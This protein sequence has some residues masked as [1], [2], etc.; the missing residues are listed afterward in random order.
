MKKPNQK[1]S[2]VYHFSTA[3]LPALPL[4]ERM[5]EMFPKLEFNYRYYERGCCFQGRLLVKNG[6]VK[7][8]MTKEYTGNRGG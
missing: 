6:E 2:I 4:V 7:D 1:T 8:N 3:W 5:S